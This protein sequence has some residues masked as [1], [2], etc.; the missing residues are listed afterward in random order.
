MSPL[1]VVSGRDVV[2]AL[3]KIGYEYDRQRS[4]HIVLRLNRE[5]Y[6][7]IV[8]PNHRQVAKGTLRKIIREA[9][10]TVDEFNGL[11]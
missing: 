11:L 9:G 10:L 8:V 3:A 2:S 5:P 4:S 1:P 7:R 6:R